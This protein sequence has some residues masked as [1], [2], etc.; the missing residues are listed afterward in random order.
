MIWT[1]KSEKG[2]WNQETSNCRWEEN[3][4]TQTSTRI[5]QATATSTIIS[6]EYMIN[7]ITYIYKVRICESHINADYW[8]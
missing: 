2:N 4:S 6:K 7:M 1:N 3:C 5:T 8:M